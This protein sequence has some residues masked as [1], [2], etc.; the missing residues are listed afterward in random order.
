M[1][2]LAIQ[3]TSPSTFTELNMSNIVDKALTVFKEH[4][5]DRVKLCSISVQSVEKSILHYCHQNCL[6]SG[7]IKTT[8]EIAW[9]VDKALT[10]HAWLK[11]EEIPISTCM[12]IMKIRN[13][14]YG[15][16][17]LV[18]CGTLGI[19]VRSIDKLCRLE[20]MLK[21]NLQD[22]NESITDSIIDL[23]NYSILAILLLKGELS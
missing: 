6:P 5:L 10:Y 20:N 9:W 2:K 15:N 17:P 12:N 21:N 14:N 7:S 19:V 23:F 16:R 11:A 22:E 13:K 4:R 3:K 8:K 18:L 1:K